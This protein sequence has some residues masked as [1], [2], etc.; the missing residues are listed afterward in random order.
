MRSVTLTGAGG[1]VAAFLGSLCC[2][3]PLLFVTLGVGAGFAS[4]LERYRPLFGVLMAASLVL[5]FGTVY[6]RRVAIARRAPGSAPSCAPARP[7]D[8]ALLWGATA[9]ALVLWTFPRWSLWLL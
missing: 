3:G 2:I 8:V 7:G 9:L 6:G 1:V 5:G 4:A